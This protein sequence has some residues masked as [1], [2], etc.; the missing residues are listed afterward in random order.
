M[1]QLREQSALERVRKSWVKFTQDRSPGLWQSPFF[2]SGGGTSKF[3]GQPLFGIHTW[4]LVPY[5]GSLEFSRCASPV[6]KHL[7][8]DPPQG[9]VGWTVGN[10][11]TSEGIVFETFTVWE[12]RSDMAKFY[13]SSVHHDGM[14]R[15]SLIPNT[16]FA[17]RRFWI[18]SDLMLPS[19]EATSIRDKWTQSRA[20]VEQV[21]TERFPQAQ[22]PGGQA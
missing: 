19:R 21:K 14:K 8:V 2:W 7:E 18:E 20:F 1:A 6:V 5:F 13:H 10:K 3:D 4:F 16:L 11:L 15:A 17:A 22:A 9:L 12:K